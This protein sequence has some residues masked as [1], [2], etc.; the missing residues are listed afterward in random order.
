MHQM[1]QDIIKSC[2]SDLNEIQITFGAVHFDITVEHFYSVHVFGEKIK[3]Q[4][5]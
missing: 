2:Q 3:G 1:F 4:F 5:C